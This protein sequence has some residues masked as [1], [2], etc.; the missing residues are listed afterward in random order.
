MSC[1]QQSF[2]SCRPLNVCSIIS[3]DQMSWNP[4][5]TNSIHT[6][7][8]TNLWLSTSFY[9]DEHISFEHTYLNLTL[10]IFFKKF[11]TIKLLT[12]TRQSDCR[13]SPRCC[14]L[15][16]LPEVVPCVRCLQRVLLRLRLRVSC[17]S[18]GRRRRGA[19][20]YVQI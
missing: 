7:M 3:L 20:A 15:I 10:L 5:Q 18:A 11:I 8:H 19:L 4:T 14:H 12:E 9:R 1:S 17:A 2:A 13:L 6:C 16:R